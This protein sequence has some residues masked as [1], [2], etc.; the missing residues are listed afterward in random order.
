MRGVPC[1]PIHQKDKAPNTANGASPASAVPYGV[2]T[3]VQTMGYTFGD[4]LPFMHLVPPSDVTPQLAAVR[5]DVE[6]AIRKCDQWKPEDEAL[7][8]AY[9]D[10]ERK[11]ESAAHA[12]LDASTGTFIFTGLTVLL[13]SFF[14]ILYLHALQQISEFNRDVESFRKFM[15]TTSNAI[16]GKARLL[17]STTEDLTSSKDDFD[18]L[19]RFLLLRWME[20]QPLRET[21]NHLKR[22]DLP[23]D[24]LMTIVSGLQDQKAAIVRHLDPAAQERVQKEFVETIA[25]LGDRIG[26]FQETERRK[27][28]RRK[29]VSKPVG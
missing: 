20:E 19:I 6:S 21:L 12:N 17:E 5:R 22:V 13:T 3:S 26:R 10:T 18:L 23:V 1:S 28:E 24:R 29:L 27:L 25:T 16:E 14:L 15:E 2:R 8:A 11:L 4:P 9:R 7:N